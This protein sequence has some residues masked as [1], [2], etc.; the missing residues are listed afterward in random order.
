MTPALSYLALASIVFVS[1]EM[2]LGLWYIRK[3]RYWS[4]VR[5]TEQ[6]RLQLGDARCH[7]VRL[8]IDG[9]LKHNS[10][11][12]R[13]LY[14][15][16]TSLMRGTDHYPAISEALWKKVLKF[17]KAKKSQ[18]VEEASDWTPDVNRIAL[19]TADAIEQIWLWYMPF[20][21]TLRLLKYFLMTVGLVSYE[22]F[23][24]A[25]DTLLHKLVRIADQMALLV[26][27]VTFESHSGRMALELRLA[28]QMRESEKI[29]R[30]VSATSKAAALS[31]LTPLP[32]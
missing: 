20:G 12:F 25:A 22:R 4:A 23:D 27:R 26:R 17:E 3:R 1:C 16:Q 15:M 30:E 21:M 32:D 19:Q 7:L 11:T 2:F 10:L 6:I 9:E 31:T 13:E 5:K 8:A 18:L 14:F 24:R 29:L 28:V